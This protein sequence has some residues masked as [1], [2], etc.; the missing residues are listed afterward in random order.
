MIIS[1]E[2]SLF[3]Q[4]VPSWFERAAGAAGGEARGCWLPSVHLVT[5]NHFRETRTQL[6]IAALMELM[7]KLLTDGDVDVDHRRP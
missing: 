7:I 2:G 5:R 4:D 1:E 6:A 3:I